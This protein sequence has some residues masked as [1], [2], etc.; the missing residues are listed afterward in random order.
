MDI[1]G[2]SGSLFTTSVTM[3][4][5]MKYVFL[6]GMVFVMNAAVWGQGEGPCP[7]PFC[8]CL[9]DVNCAG[10]ECA[11][12]CQ[13]TT[14]T[15]PCSGEYT[16]V[17]KVICSNSNEPCELCFACLVVSGRTGGGN[18][19]TSNC[20]IGICVESQPYTLYSGVEYTMS[21]CLGYCTGQQGCG[22]CG[23]SCKAYGC[24]YRNVTYE[25]VPL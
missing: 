20:G 11:T 24:V 21:V 6:A 5:V 14:F 12:G 16:F 23:T 9:S 2:G 7:Q 13:T 22:S 17:A 1:L 25:C 10:S 15:V 8:K 4:P 3:R 19:H 18:C